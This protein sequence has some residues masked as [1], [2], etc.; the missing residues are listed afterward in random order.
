MI[1]CQSPMK[2]V[3]MLGAKGKVFW[4]DIFNNFWFIISDLLS[5]F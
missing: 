5:F 3:Y 4:I 2:M 1:L